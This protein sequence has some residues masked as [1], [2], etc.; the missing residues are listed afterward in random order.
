MKSLS[1]WGKKEDRQE[2]D[3]KNRINNGRAITSNVEWCI[4]ETDK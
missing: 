2:N 1:I 3:I 4:V